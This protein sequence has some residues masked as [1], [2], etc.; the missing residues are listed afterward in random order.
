[1]AAVDLK[2]VALL[3]FCALQMKFNFV[4]ETEKK[5]MLTRR[6]QLFCTASSGFESFNIAT[7]TNATMLQLCLQIKSVSY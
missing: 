6:L 5:K 4:E 2:K 7:V 3:F 1:M